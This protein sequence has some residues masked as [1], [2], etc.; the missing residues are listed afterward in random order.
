MAQAEGSL[1]PIEILVNN[2]GIPGPTAPATEMPTAEWERVLA[3]NLTGPFLCSREV[4]RGMVAIT[5][6]RLRCQMRPLRSRAK[7]VQAR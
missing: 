1:G 7:L 4:L 3:V 6:Q 5:G 2:A